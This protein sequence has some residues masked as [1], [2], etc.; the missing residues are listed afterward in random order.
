M[1]V[2]VAVARRC[3]ADVL[4]DDDVKL[5]VIKRAQKIKRQLRATLSML[6]VTLTQLKIGKIITFFFL[7]TVKSSFSFQV[8]SCTRCFSQIW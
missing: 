4:G 1:F 6:Q 7:N 8:L 2:A 5:G 3:Y